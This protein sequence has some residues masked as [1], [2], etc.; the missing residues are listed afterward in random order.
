MSL[1]AQIGDTIR[2]YSSLSK[3]VGINIIMYPDNDIYSTFVEYCIKKIDDNSIWY[4]EDNL[5][6]NDL[7]KVYQKDNSSHLYYV[8]RNFFSKYDIIKRQCYVYKT[9][10]ETDYQSGDVFD[11]IYD[12]N[13]QTFF[14]KKNTTNYYGILVKRIYV[15]VI[16]SMFSLPEDYLED[17]LPQISQ[18][19][20]DEKF[21]NTIDNN[22][23]NFEVGDGLLINDNEYYVV[24]ESR[25][26]YGVNRK[27]F[28]EYK[29]YNVNDKEY[30]WLKF[31]VRKYWLLKSSD[32]TSFESFPGDTIKGQ[33]Y[34]NCFDGNWHDINKDY[35]TFQLKVSD[36]ECFIKEIWMNETE[37][38]NG[39]LVSKKN[40][41]V[42][43]YD[44]QRST[45]W[46]QLKYSKNTKTKILYRNI[47]PLFQLL[48]LIFVL[49][50]L[51]N[52]KFN[53]ILILFIIALLIV[54]IF[55]PSQHLRKYKNTF[56]KWVQH[57]E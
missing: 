57:K 38:F 30:Y 44:Y 16:K 56:D 19:H 32:K 13:S 22:N 27:S 53:Y 46:K 47:I 52:L 48:L 31:I 5:T 2:V 6:Q 15:K 26:K 54:L 3:V 18:F 1:Y 29:L 14:L 50:C 33:Q 37:Y 39:I 7:L 4:I 23:G 25:L 51:F 28:A 34:R 49:I 45:P 42:I 9:I 35:S 17:R 21:R 43:K 40:M 36:K 8:R 12:E 55:Y 41:P 24:S 20:N 10:G 11:Y